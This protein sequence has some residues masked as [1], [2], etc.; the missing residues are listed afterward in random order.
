MVRPT[1]SSPRLQRKGR[2][3]LR[4]ERSNSMCCAPQ[5]FA[6]SYHLWER[7]CQL[8]WCAVVTIESVLVTQEPDGLAMLQSCPCHRF[9]AN[10]CF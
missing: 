10:N 5:A 6:R 9:H 1:P 2:T 8:V 3:E 7:R 4:S